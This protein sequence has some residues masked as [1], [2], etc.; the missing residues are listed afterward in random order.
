MKLKNKVLTL[1]TMVPLFAVPV[2]ANSIYT[3]R[4][5]TPLGVGITYEMQRRIT[6][7]G[8]VDVHIIEVDL[9]AYGVTLGPVLPEGFGARNT[10][11]NILSESGAVAGI[12]AD[13]FDMAR[14]PSTALGQVIQNGEVLEFNERD[15]GF[16]TFMVDVFGNPLI[17][18]LEPEII[19]LNNGNR[20]FSVRAYN[21]LS[22]QIISTVFDRRAFHNTA[23][24]VNRHPYVVTIVVEGGVIT[25]ITE[26]G[27]AVYIP[28]YGFIIAVR[29]SYFNYFRNSTVIGNNA[30]IVFDAP[31][32]NLENIWQAVS[33]AGLILQNGSIVN[34]GYV[35]GRAARHPRSAV[36]I[37]SDGDTVFLVAVD[38]R[39]ASI[40]ATHAEL[41][42]IMQSIGAY[43]AMH[44]DGGGST[45]LGI[46]E[47][48]RTLSLANTPSD[49]SQRRVVNALGVF[50][51][52]PRDVLLQVEL[53]TDFSGSYIFLDDNITINAAGVNAHLERIQLDMDYIEISVYP[54]VMNVYDTFFP[55]DAGILEF[56]LLYDELESTLTIE[57]LEL[58]EIIP[59]HPFLSLNTGDTQRMTF[60]GRS[61]LGHEAPLHNINI[62]FYPEGLG[63][64]SGGVLT[65]LGETS[66][67]MRASRGSIATYISININDEGYIAPREDSVIINPY[68][69]SLP[70][71]GFG[72]D[73]TVAPDVSVLMF[74]DEQE[75]ARNTNIRN[76]ALNGF[77]TGATLG[78]FAG[79]SEIETVPGLATISRVPGYRFHIIYNTALINLDAYRGSLTNTTPYNWSFPNE[80]RNADVENAILILN[81]SINELTRDDREMLIN[82]LEQ[83]RREGFSVFLIQTDVNYTSA[84]IRNG[85]NYISLAGLFK[86][87]EV[88]NYYSDEEE[89]G[90]FHLNYDFAILRFRTSEGEIHFDV[91]HVFE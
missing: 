39:G 6:R 14:N 7:A 11:S 84:Y 79:T 83:L 24:L 71:A 64:F 32:I 10:T 9:N 28:R 86:Y 66:G 42:A 51:T 25:N 55:S 75:R 29:E 40:G 26:P 88:D 4:V 74:E 63:T 77:R 56:S 59:S 87:V 43:N 23:P 73:I 60:S 61:P 85:V 69:R 82:A 70:P 68:L 81:R 13:F 67:V 27:E 8:R 91:Q 18:Y 45:S 20:G 3:H 54:P 50:N 19:F 22:T 33:G 58:G 17:R 34:Y 36:G 52:A 41:G 2:M 1:L 21:H 16:F 62:E 78:I 30:E 44:F 47:P 49:G 80:V 76:E 65:I 90:E 72:F 89:H 35:P 12:N 37:S 53:Y 31:H 5:E 57:V 15:A 38:G 46:R 48:G